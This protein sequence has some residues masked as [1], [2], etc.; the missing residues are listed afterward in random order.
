[1]NPEIE[2]TVWGVFVK[3][4]KESPRMY[5]APLVALFKAVRSAF[6]YIATPKPSK[7][8]VERPCEGK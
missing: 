5:F 2:P 3:A 6:G 8:D 1:M 4:V 7:P